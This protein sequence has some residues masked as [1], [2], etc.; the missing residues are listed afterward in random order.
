VTAS[1]FDLNFKPSS[2]QD[3][4]KPPALKLPQVFILPRTADSALQSV[5]DAQAAAEAQQR[6]L[7]TTGPLAEAAAEGNE[8]ITSILS[9]YTTVQQLY[10]KAVLRF[11]LQHPKYIGSPA[12]EG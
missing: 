7:S 2:L 10:H 11:L 3:D 4:E 5:L 12:G 8:L 6:E 1:A 9:T